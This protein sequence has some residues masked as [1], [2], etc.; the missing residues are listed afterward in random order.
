[1]NNAEYFYNVFGYYASE[2]R[3]MSEDMFLKWLEE[4]APQFV[5]KVIPMSNSEILKRIGEVEQ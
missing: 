3:Y 4:D 2:I 5:L 1:M